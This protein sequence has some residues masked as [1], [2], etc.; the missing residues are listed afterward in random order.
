M[1]RTLNLVGQEVLF[2][3]DSLCLH[4]CGARAECN[5]EFGLWSRLLLLLGRLEL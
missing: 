5:S 2:E 1:D 3:V 4:V